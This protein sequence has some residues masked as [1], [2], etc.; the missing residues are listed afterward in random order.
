[1]CERVG[2]GSKWRIA[3]TVVGLAISASAL[4]DDLHVPAGNLNLDSGYGV[5]VGGSNAITLGGVHNWSVSAGHGAGIGNYVVAIGY[6]AML[7]NTGDYNVAIGSQAMKGNTGSSCTAMGKNAMLENTGTACLA[8]GHDSLYKNKGWSCVGVGGGTLY[9]NMAHGCVAIGF[10]ALYG[11]ASTGGYT[12]A[13]GY[14]A[15]KYNTKRSCI[16]IGPNTEATDHHQMVIGS[17]AP[18]NR[19]AIRNVYIGRGVWAASPEDVT[20]Q[21]TSGLGSAR[22]ADLILAG[23]ASVEGSPGRVIAARELST[24]VLEITGGSD[25]AESFP[26]RAPSPRHR[27]DMAVLLLKHGARD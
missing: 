10:Q 13:I 27:N 18:D 9:S 23:G 17:D 5:R 22:G 6:N 4:A 24:P 19:G 2:I 3:I 25:L 15:G 12:T 8:I 7:G 14:Q 11:N 1:M 26:V 20:I 16:L 21:A